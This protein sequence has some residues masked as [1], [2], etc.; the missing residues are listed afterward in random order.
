MLLTQLGGQVNVP[1][2]TSEL[3]SLE[4]LGFTDRR[5]NTILLSRYGGDLNTVVNILMDE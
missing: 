1:N 3:Q 5:R 4:N 2:Y